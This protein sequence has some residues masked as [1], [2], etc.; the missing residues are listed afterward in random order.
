MTRLR[1]ARTLCTLVILGTCVGC[2]DTPT[3]PTSAVADVSASPFSSQ[4]APKGTATRAF[5]V[6]TPGAVNITL[7]STNPAGIV[8]GLGVGIPRSNGAGCSLSRSVETVAGPSPQITVTVD[9]GT[10][11]AQ[12]YDLGTLTDPLAFTLSIS[13]P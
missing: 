9:T 8:V 10:Y 6:S 4:L 11:C 3:S 12:I 5:T 2:S 1:T 13:R 7:S